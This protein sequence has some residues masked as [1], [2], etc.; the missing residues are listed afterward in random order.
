[1]GNCCCLGSS[2]CDTVEERSGLLQDATKATVPTAEAGMVDAFH[3]S[4]EA[5]VDMRKSDEAEIK[6]EEK[7][8][9]V[10]QSPQAR[11]T[12]PSK[13]QENGPLQKESTKG[14][15]PS[16]SKG[17]GLENEDSPNKAQ[18]KDVE[19][20]D[21]DN[22]PVED[23][24]R[25]LESPQTKCATADEE[26][27]TAT[28]VLP[29]QEYPAVAQEKKSMSQEADAASP[30]NPSLRSDILTEHITPETACDEDKDEEEDN[31]S[32]AT[33]NN[34]VDKPSG[35]SHCHEVPSLLDS[36]LPVEAGQPSSSSLPSREISV[37]PVVTGSSPQPPSPS[38]APS[39]RAVAK[40]RDSENETSI[41]YK[42]GGAED[43][44][45]HDGPEPCLASDSTLKPNGVVPDPSSSV[46]EPVTTSPSA[47]SESSNSHPDTEPDLEGT[48]IGLK[49]VT[50]LENL[51]EDIEEDIV[52]ETKEEDRDV[53]KAQE[54]EEAEE[55]MESSSSEAVI[56]AEKEVEDLDPS[57]K[58]NLMASTSADV[59]FEASPVMDQGD[60]AEEGIEDSD[61]D[62][63][64]GA[65]E[66]SP[67][68]CKRARTVPLLEITPPKVEDRCSLAPAVDILSYCER[69]WKGNTAKS[70][71][72]RKG[73]KEMS[74]RFGRLRRVRG[75]NYCALRATLFQVLSQ[76]A[77]LPDWLQKQNVAT[78]TEELEAREGLISRWTFPE[79][80]QQA[81]GIGDATQQLIRYMEL[82][83]NKWQAAVSCSSASERQHLC[84]EVFQGG[85]EELGLLEALKLLM[86]SRAVELHSRMQ[87]G[88]D[89]PVFCW[90]LFARDS[91]ECPRTFL[92]NHLS[93]VG[94]SGG[95]EQVEMFLL[96]Y[97]LQSTIEVYRLYMS[98]T[99]EFVTYYPDDHKEDWP[100]VCL[101]TEDDRHYNVPVAEAAELPE[102][103]THL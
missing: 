59:D 36:W 66:L 32:K 13:T 15:M 74:H 77:R 87:D 39:I 75:D 54:D 73:Y 52:V 80:C 67:T 5:N 98:D 60:F 62:L 53:P 8:V 79:E 14:K 34:A 23:L 50:S 72:I 76:S 22:G 101:V 24:R 70:A 26:V 38:S 78:L 40:E 102:E 85:E 19:K 81:E 3:E 88:G 27:F 90:L 37:E 82:L 57:G 6:K 25:T 41:V 94:F 11:E 4:P 46:R 35:D 96:G 16:P 93:R 9:K 61:E 65:E 64:R 95:L 45:S 21:A 43:V 51:G 92:S 44:R 12:E 55:E 1:M 47:A 86:L 29:V 28:K 10:K 30:E 33:V 31:S 89:V 17:T 84:E 20:S 69:E 56:K 49:E 91:S 58:E 83:R 18:D 68:Q 71:L 63:Y 99:E 2:P 100:S 48:T 97:A 103:L 7:L 42:Q